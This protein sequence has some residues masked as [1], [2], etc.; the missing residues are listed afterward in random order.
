M[1]KNVK[2]S[3]HI[4]VSG[5]LIATCHLG[6]GCCTAQ[7]PPGGALL[8]TSVP[9]FTS[10]L[11]TPQELPVPPGAHR[12]FHMID[13]ILSDPALTV[14]PASP[15][16]LQEPLCPPCLFFTLSFDIQ[17]KCGLLWLTTVA[18]VSHLP[19]SDPHPGNCS[20]LRGAQQTCVEGG[21]A[22]QHRRSRD[23]LSQRRALDGPGEL[24]PGCLFTGAQLR[25]S[26]VVLML[27]ML[28]I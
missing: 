4:S 16:G 15:A 20:T 10:L 7:W 13:R 3:T 5:E 26:A 1:D 19:P 12:L 24:P 28:L 11:G 22:E 25:I 23:C 14:P 2:N 6:W 21:A 27:L 18:G 8:H 9:S 17:S